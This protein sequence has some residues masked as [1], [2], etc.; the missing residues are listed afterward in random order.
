V[1]AAA[2]ATAASSRI[3]GWG[4]FIWSFGHLVIGLI[5]MS[6]HDQATR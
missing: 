5:K 3:N 6:Q 1:S 4:S 2:A